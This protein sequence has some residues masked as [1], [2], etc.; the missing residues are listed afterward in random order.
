MPR[1]LTLTVVIGLVAVLVASSASPVRGAEDGLHKTDVFVSGTEGYHTFRIPSVIV[2]KKGTLLAFCEGRKTSRADLGNNDMMLKR[3]TDGGKTWGKLQLVYEEGGDRKIT[4]GNPTAVVD[5]ETGVILLLFA[6]QTRDV[7]LTR[8]VDDGKSWSK[9]V[10]ITQQVTK[11]NWKFY[12]VGP[13]VGMQIRSGPHKG[14]LVIPAYHRLTADKSGA[15]RSHV[16]TSDDQGKSWQL[17][18]SVGPHTNECQV[19][20]VSEGG[21][22]ILLINTRNHWARSGGRRELAGRRITAES[23]DGGKTWSQPT[24]DKTLIEPTCQAS[25]LRYVRPNRGKMSR[26][27]FAN[28]ASA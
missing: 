12:V 19:A 2:T 16:F 25:L 5:R 22:S 18:G 14:R 21:K 27:L 4:I 26:L 1:H 13:G 23:R 28:P 6:R 10:D 9:P 20:E 15:S 7:L 8:S 3:S 11:P 24:F 17:G